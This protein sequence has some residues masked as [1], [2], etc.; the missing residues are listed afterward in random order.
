MAVLFAFSSAGSQS[1]ATSP[2][3]DPAEEKDTYEVYSQV[4]R[5]RSPSVETW[6][7]VQETKP[8]PFCLKPAQDLA[9]IYQPV[10]DGYSIKNKSKLTLERKFGLFAYVMVSPQ[11]YWGRAPSTNLVTFSAVGFNKDRTRAGV[12]Y[13]VGNSA[14]SSGTCL[15][16]VRQDGNWKGNSDIRQ[17]C[18]FGGAVYF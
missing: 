16:L 4:L 14:G 2:P 17:G 18:G 9:P 12:C 15:L 7:I 8:F 10:L 3:S 5:D 1:P 11:E 13:S 6:R